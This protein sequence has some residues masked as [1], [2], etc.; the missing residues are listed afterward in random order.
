MSYSFYTLDVFTNQ[1]FCGNQLAVF[2][3]AGG[4]SPEQMAKIAIE[5]NFSETVF[6][7]PPTDNT[8]E[9]GLRIFTPG[10]EIPFAGH[11]TIGTAYLLGYLGMVDISKE[12]NLI[13]LGEKV[14]NVPVTINAIDGKVI[15]STLQAPQPPEFYPEIPP[16]ED[17]AKVL[18]L[19][20][21]DL[22]ATHTPQA[23]SCGLPFLIIPLNSSEALSTCQINNEAWQKTLSHHIAPHVYSCYQIDE[24]H[25]R[26]RMFA[27]AL[28]ITEDPA[29]GSAATAFA[30]YLAS[31]ESTADGHFSWLIEQGG[32]INRPSKIIATADKQNQ[33]ITQISV[34]G[35]S[36]II[37]QGSL[38]SIISVG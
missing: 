38:T 35:E 16:L 25:W 20:V 32:E 5:F 26:V 36:V 37:T 13:T 29:T 3:Q 34:E 21:D 24:Y 31:Y 9:Y 18:S 30:G 28:N 14:G 10:G 15:S 1:P 6:V 8:M 19:S 22:S 4:L 2:P 17:L 33:E 23:V 12:S 27:P 11:P 7:F